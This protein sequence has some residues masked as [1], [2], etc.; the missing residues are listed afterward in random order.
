[1]P[2][3]AD[4]IAAQQVQERLKSLNEFVRDIEKKRNACE[5]IVTA[6]QQYTAEEKGQSAQVRVYF[7]FLF[8]V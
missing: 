7:D 5:Q 1:M 2:F 4:V 3:T 8:L 6:L